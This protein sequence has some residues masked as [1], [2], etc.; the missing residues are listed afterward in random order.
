MSVASR[1]GRLVDLGSDSPRVMYCALVAQVVINYDAPVYVKTYVHRAGSCEHLASSRQA[2]T[3]WVP[4]HSRARLTRCT[5]TT[6]IRATHCVEPNAAFVSAVCSL[7]PGRTARAGRTGD[8]YT[9]LRE[10]QVRSQMMPLHALAL[11]LALWWK[12]MLP[13]LAAAAE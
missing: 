9:V 5:N 13:W 1:W 12:N 10:D 2:E 8:V 3:S 6:Q 11:A 7:S 4:R